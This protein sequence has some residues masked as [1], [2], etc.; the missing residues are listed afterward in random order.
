MCIM[1]ENRLVQEEQQSTLEIFKEGNYEKSGV[2]TGQ[3]CDV[4]NEWNI[5]K[6]SGRILVPLK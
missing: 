4:K 6:G 1:K 3:Q 5:F 2:L